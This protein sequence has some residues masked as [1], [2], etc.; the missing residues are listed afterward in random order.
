MALCSQVRTATID[1]QGGSRR[2]DDHPQEE[3]GGDLD[4]ANF[5]TLDSVGEDGEDA[6]LVFVL[7]V[8]F[9]ICLV[10]THFV[11]AQVCNLQLKNILA[12]RRERSICNAL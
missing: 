9:V 12:R 6:F 4:L 8:Q 11:V 5:M 2:P 1:N 10:A 7:F 3:E